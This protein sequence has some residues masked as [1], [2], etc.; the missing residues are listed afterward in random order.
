MSTEVYLL[1]DVTDPEIAK[2]DPGQILSL[3]HFESVY[4]GGVFHLTK[5]T[6]VTYNPMLEAGIAP[7]NKW[8]SNELERGKQVDQFKGQVLKIIDTAS[9]DSALRTN[10]SIYL[11]IST[12]LSELSTSKTQRKI[13]LVYSDLMENTLQMSFYKKETFSL[14]QSNPQKISYYFLSQSNLPSLLGIEVQLIYQPKD[15]SDD[16]RYQLVA[17]FFKKMLEGRGAKVTVSAGINQ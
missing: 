6:D 5:V 7:A 11:P 12:A 1:Y 3:Y 10:S 2:P 14:L 13:L 4:N 8:L 17:G 15:N 16:Q 9:N